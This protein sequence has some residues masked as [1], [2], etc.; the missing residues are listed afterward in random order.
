M[1]KLV[2][3]SDAPAG[4][5]KPPA[6]TF[7]LGG[8]RAG[9]PPALAPLLAGNG[10]GTSANAGSGAA[11]SSIV[12]H[13]KHSYLPS[14]YAGAGVCDVGLRHLIV[15]LA[16]VKLAGVAIA[17]A[18][19]ATRATSALAARVALLEAALC[20]IASGHYYWITKVRTQRL[21]GDL[22]T[23]ASLRLASKAG[24]AGAAAE[25]TADDESGAGVALLELPPSLVP[26]TREQRRRAFA[27]EYAVDGLRATDWVSTVRPRPC[28]ERHLQHRTPNTHT[29]IC[30]P[31][32]QLYAYHH[33]SPPAVLRF[34][35][36]TF[37]MFC[38]CAPV[39]RSASS[40]D[41][42]TRTEPSIVAATRR[43]FRIMQ[44]GGLTVLAHCT[45]FD[46]QRRFSSRLSYFFR[47]M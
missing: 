1:L 21:P 40:A 12:R 26:S 19:A 43:F 46:A 11:G 18:L 17:C 14:D 32:Q 16:M 13:F 38:A 25:A 6:F 36:Q 15:R 4:A 2:P 35:A 31:S 20:A 9:A 10:K 45:D 30:T 23:A 47:L 37:W 27:A 8:A 42:N 39:A 28:S 7:T 5:A 33:V 44:P 34:L 29:H 22:G 24:A 3:L 41:A